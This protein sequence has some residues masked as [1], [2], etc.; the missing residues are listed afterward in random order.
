MVI[1][2]EID[3]LLEEQIKNGDSIDF[4]DFDIK[5]IM[6]PITKKYDHEYYFSLKEELYNYS[7]YIKSL[8]IFPSELQDIIRKNSELVMKSIEYYYNAQFEKAR[9][10]ISVIINDYINNEFIVSNIYDSYIF[11][12]CDFG[13]KSNET[14]AIRPVGLF[15]ARDSVEQVSKQNMLHIPLSKREVVSMQRFG[16]SGVPCIYAATSTYCCWLELNMPAQ[17]SF[18]ASLIR[19]PENIKVFNLAI[20]SKLMCSSNECINGK[21]L[22][23]L[24]SALSLWPLICA[25]SYNILE[26]N[27]NFKSEYIISQL[28]MQCLQDLD[29]DAVAYCSKKIYDFRA[30]PYAINVAIPVKKDFEINNEY[31][32]KANKVF[33]NNPVC[34][35]EFVEKTKQFNLH[36]G[37]RINLSFERDEE[38]N[39]IEFMGKDMDF[40]ALNFYNYDNYLFHMRYESF[41]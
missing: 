10:C 11:H 5:R 20:S 40:K 9:K 2:F 19:F 23:L 34:Y 30:Y 35:K 37:A 15:R 36:E 18:Y 33:L 39:N 13:K 29:I 12:K 4:I 21:G 1:K 22:K 26:K 6:L 8:G 32:L 31:W 25:T 7:D 41:F 24:E 27:R 3:N 28:V 17:D 16:M 14:N 38:L